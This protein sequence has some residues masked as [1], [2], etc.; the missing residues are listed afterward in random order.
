MNER[1]NGALL[2]GVLLFERIDGPQGLSGAIPLFRTKHG[3]GVQWKAR[4]DAV[5]VRENALLF[6]FKARG[7]A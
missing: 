2:P 4:A 7:V 5:P 6:D 3:R 1:P